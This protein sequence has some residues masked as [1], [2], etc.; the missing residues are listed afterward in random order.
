[1]PPYIPL[2]HTPNNIP[3]SVEPENITMQHQGYPGDEA[4]E[5][6]AQRAC[7]NEHYRRYNLP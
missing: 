6:A 4:Q 3:F 2:Q 5:A 1:M 7:V